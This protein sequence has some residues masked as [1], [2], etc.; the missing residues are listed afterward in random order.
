MKDAHRHCKMQFAEAMAQQSQVIVVDNTNLKL[1][2][3]GEVSLP[4]GRLPSIFLALWAASLRPMAL[5]C[6][7]R[8]SGACGRLPSGDARGGLLEP[9]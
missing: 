2:E 5:L 9:G 1:K 8:A 7:V 6:S 4:P 3:Y